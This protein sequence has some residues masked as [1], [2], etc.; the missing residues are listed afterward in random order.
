MFFSDASFGM[1]ILHLWVP[2]ADGSSG[3]NHPEAFQRMMEME[4]WA[5]SKQVRPVNT[6]HSQGMYGHGHGPE[7]DMGFRYR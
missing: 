5:Q 7:L 1:L 6:G 2:V 3:S 4:R